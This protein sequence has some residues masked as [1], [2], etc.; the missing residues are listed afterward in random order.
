MINASVIPGN[1]NELSFQYSYTALAGIILFYKPIYRILLRHFP[2][3][4][5]APLSCSISAQIFTSVLSAYIFKEVFPSGIPASV[6]LTPL[7]TVF[8]WSSLI[9]VFIPFS[10][11]LSFEGFKIFNNILSD[12]IINTASFFSEVP[13]I[14]FNRFSFILLIIFNLSVIIVLIVPNPGLKAFKRYR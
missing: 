3:Y 8:M 9:P 10:H 13:G 6:I 4:L 11:L 12:F 1:I 5:S 14:S 2:P 7:I